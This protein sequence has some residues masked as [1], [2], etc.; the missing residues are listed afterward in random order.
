[1]TRQF[2]TEKTLAVIDMA[3]AHSRYLPLSTK[4]MLFHNMLM[5]I[6]QAISDGQPVI[7]QDFPDSS[8]ADELSCTHDF[9]VSALSGYA[10]KCF[11]K[12]HQND[13]SQE[14][15]EA[16]R[17]QGYPTKHIQ[18]C[19]LFTNRCI[20]DTAV[21]LAKQ[22]PDG[23][24][25]VMRTA[26]ASTDPADELRQ[27]FWNRFSEP[28]ITITPAPTIIPWSAHQDDEQLYFSVKARDH[29]RRDYDAYISL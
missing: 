28:N 10:D 29:M 5:Q 25:E 14:I 7:V 2:R 9:V 3:P 26:C 1:M 18:L 17:D 21:G 12:K 11:I 23:I 8:V 15:L 4:V 19:G 20:R 22:Q 27:C 13:G 6:E 24:I 16:C